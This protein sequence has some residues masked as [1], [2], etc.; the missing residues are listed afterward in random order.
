MKFQSALACFL[1]LSYIEHA[2]AE[3]VELK[4][5]VDL[6]AS[7]TGYYQI[8]NMDDAGKNYLYPGPSPDLGVTVGN[9]YIFDQ[10]S[11]SNWYHPVG[12]AY[13]PDGAHGTTWGGEEEPEVEDAD[14][15]S[16]RENGEVFTCEDV[17][18]TGLD[19]Y[20]PL[21]FYPRG[22]W[23][24]GMGKFSAQLTITRAVADKA[25]KNGG[26]LYYFCHIH[27]KMSGRIIITEEYIPELEKPLYPDTDYVPVFDSFCGTSGTSKFSRFGGRGDKNCNKRV[28]VPG[29]IDSQYEECLDAIDCKQYNEM[30]TPHADTHGDMVAV[31]SQQMISHH[32]NAVNM[33]KLSLK[34]YEDDF[35][36]AD[37][38]TILMSIINVQNFQIH[39]FRN[40]LGGKKLEP[41]WE[42]EQC[43]NTINETWNPSRDTSTPDL[44]PAKGCMS[45]EF[46]LCMKIDMF[47]SETGYYTIDGL[48][49]K[50]SPDVNVKLGESYTFDQSDP[51]NWYHPVGFAYVPDGA[52]GTTWGG[53]EEDEVESGDALQY[54]IDDAATTCKDV[55]D[56]GLNCY[57]PEFFYPQ[58]V[59]E[60]KKYSAVLTITQEVVDTAA[61]NGGVLYYFCHIHSKMSGRIIITEEYKP[62]KETALYPAVT[63][64]D[65]DTQCGTTG[66]SE[67]FT[68]WNHRFLCGELDETFEKCV[69]SLDY[70]MNTNMRYFSSEDNHDPVALFCE[71]MIPHHQNA[72][73]MAKALMKHH[74]DEVEEVEDLGGLLM[75]LINGQNYQIHQFR[76]Y[77]EEDP[78]EQRFCKKDYEGKFV[79][80]SEADPKLVTC[81]RW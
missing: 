47:A 80:D 26:V 48:E 54:L 14:A 20:E 17:G 81:K 56:T 52:H 23:K 59:W 13:V 27:S 76:A 74:P 16:Y 33:A 43:N 75:E 46:N 38:K 69:Q 31:F 53:D 18:E 34:H 29:K 78:S 28:F 51:S 22:V 79:L 64:S 21:F 19:C 35:D 3:T 9:T 39:Q 67:E 24:K 60:G 25:M 73:N 32:Q 10:S 71:Q 62:E 65:V 68:Q 45:S 44:E 61:A 66:L 42:G 12:F 7:E 1:A 15:L 55:G 8:E 36:N 41:E 40:Y 49:K 2:G 72:V 6:F 70:K 77:L 4:M 5:S 37:L 57:E 11:G 58:D 63:R 50:P 30:R